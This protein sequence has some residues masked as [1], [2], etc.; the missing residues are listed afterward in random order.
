MTT[1]DQIAGSLRRP[2]GLL[3]GKVAVITGAGSGIGQMCAA[4]FVNEGARVLAADISGGQVET[5]AALGSSVTPFQM[6]VR[7][8]EEIEAMFARA[9]FSSTPWA[10]RKVIEE[11]ISAT[12]RPV[13]A[14]PSLVS[15][16]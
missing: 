14:P 9:M 3:E 12:S 10:M 15:T 7:R 13:N 2:G 1:A 16:L 5:A 8:E 6:D 11:G 4:V